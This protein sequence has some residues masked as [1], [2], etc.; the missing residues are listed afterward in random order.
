[1]TRTRRTSSTP[2]TVRLSPANWIAIAALSIAIVGPV[3]AA[4]IDIR[5]QLAT[6]QSEVQSLSRRVD[7]I[8][9]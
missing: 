1:M 3:L 8:D 6:M 9:R 7:Q 5:V 4:W 2:E